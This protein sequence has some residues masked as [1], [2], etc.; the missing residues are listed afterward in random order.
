MM[1]DNNTSGAEE[2]PQTCAE[3]Q[4]GAKILRAIECRKQ[5]DSMR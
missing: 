4:A 2:A 1:N 3:Q 5:E